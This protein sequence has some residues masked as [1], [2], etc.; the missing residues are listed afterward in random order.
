MET[1]ADFFRVF[2]QYRLLEGGLEDFVGKLRE[3][4]RP[5]ILVFYGDHQP[6]VT[7]DYN[8]AIF[9]KDEYPLTHVERLYHTQYVVWANYPVAGVKPSQEGQEDPDGRATSVNYL[10]ALTLSLAGADLTPYQKAQLA[11]GKDMPVVNLYGYQDVDGVWHP[12]SVSTDLASSESTTVAADQQ[13]GPIVDPHGNS[14]QAQAAKQAYE[15]L[16][17]LQYRNFAKRIQ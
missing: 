5:V 3:L 8:D 4:D 16:A 12:N 9:G 17:W 15:D 1:D 13:S 14:P 7:E 2:P 6:S 11:C 10:A